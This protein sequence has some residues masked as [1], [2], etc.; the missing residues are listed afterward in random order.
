MVF[1]GAA[2]FQGRTTT[3]DRIQVGKDNPE[4]SLQKVHD[5]C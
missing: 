2:L 5:S 4:C 3:F 1:D